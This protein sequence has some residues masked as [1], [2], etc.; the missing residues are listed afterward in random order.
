MSSGRLAK[1]LMIWSVVGVAP[2]QAQGPHDPVTGTWS[3]YIGQS[4]ANPSSVTV[5]LKL[6]PDGTLSGKVSG[7]KLTPGEIGSGTFDRTTGMLR[8]I[9]VVRATNGDRGG[10]V[11]FDG[12]IVRDSA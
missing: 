6:A 2:M 9:V 4:E 1:C 5:E 3:G 10:N 7:P 8:F 12:R 11:S